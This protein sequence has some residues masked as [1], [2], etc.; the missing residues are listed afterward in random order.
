MIRRAHVGQICDKDGNS[1]PPDTPPPPR[2]S[3]KGSDDWTPYNNRLQFEVADFLFRVNQM[4]AGH[5]NF[6]LGLWAA[7]LAIHDDEPPFSN[8]THLYSDIDLTPLGDVKWE[9]FSL[10]FNRCRPIEN[11]PPW[12]QAE[13]DVW[14]RDPRTLVR[15]LLSNPDFKTG[16]DYA[17]YQERTGVPGT[18]NRVH[19]FQNFMSGNWAWNQAVGL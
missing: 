19:R 7:S 5:I 12:M 17:P 9:S 16:F 14:F 4:S 13:Y 1:V 18:A 6:V 10:Q 15:N 11:T 8:A 2:G 3:D